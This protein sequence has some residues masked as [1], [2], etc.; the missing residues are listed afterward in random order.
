MIERRIT[1]GESMSIGQQARFRRGVIDPGIAQAVVGCHWNLVARATSEVEKPVPWMQG[2]GYRG[3]NLRRV[4][5][6]SRT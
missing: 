5:L 1:E 2:I 3:K 4:A 6:G